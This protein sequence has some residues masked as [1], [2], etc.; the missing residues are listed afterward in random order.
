MKRIKILSLVLAV[1]MLLTCFGA[2]SQKP[3]T[4]PTS[5]TPN[6]SQNVETST[7]KEAGKI[8]FGVT[9]GITGSAPAEGQ[10]MVNTVNLA[11]KEINAAGGVL[12]KEFVPVIEDDQFNAEGGL[13][14]LQKL[15]SDE[16]IVALIG[17][18]KTAVL[19]AGIDLIKI[20]TLYGASSSTFYEINNP[21]CF[22]VFGADEVLAEAGANYALENWKPKNVWILNSTDDVGIGAGKIFA[23]VCD[24]EGVKYITDSFNV[25]DRDFTSQIM[26]AK[27]AGCD[28]LL[29]YGHANEMSVLVRQLYEYG[30]DIPVM[31]GQGMGNATFH[32]ATDSK[33]SDGTYAYHG[34]DLSSDDPFIKDFVNRYKAEYNVAPDGTAAGWYKIV[35][36]LAEVIEK[37]GSTDKDAIVEQ[38]YNVK[39]FRTIT[40]VLTCDYRRDMV[41]QTNICKNQDGHSVV[42]DVAKAE[43][44]AP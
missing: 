18:Q 2:C 24:R 16:R 36:L 5:T 10:S 12:G 8:Y 39:D 3:D 22:R 37:A 19:L 23:S 14:A 38:L 42:V 43:I 29:V 41:H 25:G 11:C 32:N 40:T 15:T 9:T 35:Y 21:Y 17:M 1:M 27:N 13:I 44:I 34:Y 30:Y 26:N 20:P 7:A 6:T 28:A 31:G 33:Y 4:T